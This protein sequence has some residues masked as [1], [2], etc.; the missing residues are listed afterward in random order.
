MITSDCHHYASIDLEDS[1]TDQ[2]NTDDQV[3]VV[4]KTVFGLICWHI[5]LDLYRPI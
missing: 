3:K 4:Q 1:T 5:Y 2:S